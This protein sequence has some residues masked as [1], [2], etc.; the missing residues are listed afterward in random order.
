MKKLK[1]FLHTYANFLIRER[2]DEEKAASIL[3]YILM[4]QPSI[5]KQISSMSDHL[6][7]MDAISLSYVSD[8]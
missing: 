6:L 5:I 8:L 2:K 1:E 3:T 4:I 7:R